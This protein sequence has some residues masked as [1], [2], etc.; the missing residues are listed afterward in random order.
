[1]CND[2]LRSHLEDSKLKELANK[3]FRPKNLENLVVPRVNQEV[4]AKLRQDTRNQDLRM[5]KTHELI[6]KALI[7]VL[8][9]VEMLLAFKDNKGKLQPLQ[10]L[11]WTSDTLQLLMTL[12]TEFS[13]RR[14]EI[15][16]P[17]LSFAFKQLCS[18]QNPVTN[19]LFGDD[20]T[21]QIREIDDAQKLGYKVAAAKKSFGFKSS[22]SGATASS[23]R[24]HPY[25]R[26]SG[27]GQYQSGPSNRSFLRTGG[28][29]RRSTWPNRKSR[30]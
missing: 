9:G 10:L 3:H 28:Q 6:T 24:A 13:F 14:R 2:G 1:M 19:N 20:L 23:S 5:Q 8:K 25:R 27:R 12:F 7:P 18:T 30:D 22:S 21:K 26:G 16:K 4:W 11:N 17:E 29:G 15:I